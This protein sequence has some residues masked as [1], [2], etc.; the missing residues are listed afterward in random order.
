MRDDDTIIAALYDDQLRQSLVR[1]LDRS[2]LTP[3]ILPSE[4]LSKSKIPEWVS[5]G[6]AG[7]THYVSVPAAQREDALKVIASL[8]RICQGCGAYFTEEFEH[9]PICNEAW[10]ERPAE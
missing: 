1:E 5:S 6:G 9:C 2:G 8:T 7:A 10:A 3:K 4:A